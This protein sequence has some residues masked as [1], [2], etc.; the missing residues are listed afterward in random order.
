MNL[1]GNRQMNVLILV[2][3]KKEKQDVDTLDIPETKR[4]F[5]EQL[6]QATIDI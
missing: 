4:L 1:K 2:Y 6:S 3:S 5:M